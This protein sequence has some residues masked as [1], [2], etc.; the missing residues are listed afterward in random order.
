MK[1]LTVFTLALTI[2][3]L[4]VTTQIYHVL[5]AHDMILMGIVCFTA[6]I[7]CLATG[8]VALNSEE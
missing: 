3:L 1:I 6:L 7:G 8:Y 2:C 5:T 4:I